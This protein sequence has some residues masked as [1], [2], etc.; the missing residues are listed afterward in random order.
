MEIILTI[1]ENV[2]ENESACVIQVVLIQKI[3]TLFLFSFQ[4]LSTCIQ[5]CMCYF[6]LRYIYAYTLLCLALSL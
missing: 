4:A 2:E 6:I 3:F 1:L 5:I